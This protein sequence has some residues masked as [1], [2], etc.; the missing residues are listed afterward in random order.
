M[1]EHTTT[2]PHHDAAVPPHQ[3]PEPKGGSPA[4]RCE[5][6]RQRT[7]CASRHCPYQDAPFRGWPTPGERTAGRQVVCAAPRNP[8]RVLPIPQPRGIPHTTNANPPRP[9]TFNGMGKRRNATSMRTH[10]RP[11][12]P[13]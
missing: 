4:P 13:T 9:Q 7:R 3:Q 10:Y 5:R 11:D 6:R 2:K 12:A 1:P 8:F